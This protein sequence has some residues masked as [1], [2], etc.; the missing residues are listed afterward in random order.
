MPQWPIIAPS[1]ASYV[2]EILQS[3]LKEVTDIL[4]Q[5]RDLLEHFAQE[6]LRK[7][8][9]E[10]DEIQAIFDKFNIKPLSGRVP[11]RV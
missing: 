10:Y 7:E 2:Q 9:L 4:K 1:I 3:C 6:L 8:E 5:H 11:F